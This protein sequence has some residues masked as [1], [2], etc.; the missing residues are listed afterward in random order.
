M[1]L[2]V[3]VD[4]TLLIPIILSWILKRVCDSCYWLQWNISGPAR[5]FVNPAKG[6]Q[7]VVQSSFKYSQGLGIFCG[8]QYGFFLIFFYLSEIL[9]F[10][11]FIFYFFCF[12]QYDHKFTYPFPSML[13]SSY[14]LYISYI[15]LSRFGKA[16]A[17]I[18]FLSFFMP[19]LCYP[20]RIC[21]R[22][23]D[24]LGFNDYRLTA[25]V[26]DLQKISFF[27]HR[28]QEWEYSRRAEKFRNR[29][30]WVLRD[31]LPANYIFLKHLS[32][33]VGEVQNFDFRALHHRNDV[34]RFSSCRFELS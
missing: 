33:E 12:S 26:D 23:G 32:N 21:A 9:M 17:C 1:R 4:I 5:C 30:F 22:N 2:T 15:E 18:I 10:A 31:Q 7:S 20:I 13:T 16:G 34:D 14:F 6:L 28:M 24:F 19:Y 27:R 3:L 8:S 11:L 25:P 29:Y